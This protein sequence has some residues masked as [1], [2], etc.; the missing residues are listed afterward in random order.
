MPEFAFELIFRAVTS[1]IFVGGIVSARNLYVIV[2]D[3]LCFCAQ[4][5]RESLDFLHIT[6]LIKICMFNY[7]SKLPLWELVVCSRFGVAI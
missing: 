1:F 7:R 3:S 2:D 6:H 4:N 5:M